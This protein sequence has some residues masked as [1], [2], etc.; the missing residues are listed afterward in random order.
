MVFPVEKIR[1]AAADDWE[2]SGFRRFNAKEIF[3]AGV[4]F[5]TVFL[6]IAAPWIERWTGGAVDYLDISFVGIACSILLFL[7]GIRVL[8]WK[9]TEEFVSWGGI[10]LVAT[11]LA[12]G[13]TIYRTGAAEWLAWVLFNR[14]G[15]L[16]PGIRIFLVVLGVSLLKVMFS[17]NT[18]TG[19]IVVPLLI[20]LSKNLG[21]NPVTLAIPAGITSSLAFIL[22]TSTPT[23]VIPYSSGHFSISEM[24]RAGLIMTLASS[25]CVTASMLVFGG[26]YFP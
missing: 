24:A 2:S 11:G 5:L 1:I 18:V 14:I 19:I 22:V 4:F 6:W 16:N 20:A 23:N 21:L 15:S 12:V 17:S 13:M 3:T 25:L 10:I 26:R 7:P 8:E 9:E